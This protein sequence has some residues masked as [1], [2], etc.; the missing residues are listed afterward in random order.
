MEAMGIISNV[1]GL[2]LILAS[3][4]VTA[5]WVMQERP[6]KKWASSLCLLS[7]FVGFLLMV[8]QRAIEVTFGGIGTIK[9]AA[10]KASLD[11]QAIAEI[12]KRIE[13]QSATVDLVAGAAT[14]AEALTRELSEKSATAEAKLEDVNKAVSAARAKVTELEQIA[15]FTRTALAAQNDERK[16]FDRLETWANDTRFALRAE[17][18]GARVSVLDA[19]AQPFYS[20]GFSIPWKAGLNPSTFSLNDLRREYKGAPVFIRPALIE[21]IWNRQDIP[22][23][24]RAAFLVDVI[25]G[26]D[27]LKAVEYAGRYLNDALQTK[28]KPVAAKPLLE[29]WEKSKDSIK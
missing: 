7:V 17:A 20:S 15:E 12:R 13:A 10:E 25:R 26:D 19:H 27:S 29:A 8:Y 1:L 9:A 2:V 22:K 6:H 18:L 5:W 28:L 4:G 24:D 16:A 3:I 11:A 21:Y 14:R 23:R